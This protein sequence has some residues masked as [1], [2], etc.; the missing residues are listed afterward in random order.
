M[1]HFSPARKHS[2]EFSIFSHPFSETFFM[3]ALLPH[4]TLLPYAFPTHGVK[5]FST[6]RHAPWETEAEKDAEPDAYTSFN[7]THYCGDTPAHISRCRDWLCNKLDITQEQLW[8]PRQT[9][10]TRVLCIDANFIRSTPNKQNNLLDSVDA[11][12]TDIPRQCIGVSTA[13]CVPILLYDKKHR[14]VAA[15]HSGWR[16]TVGDIPGN[17]LRV[18]SQIYGTQACEV[19]AI[20]GPSISPQAFEVGTEVVNTFMQAGFPSSIVMDIYPNKHTA[21]SMKPHIDL[22]A[23]NSWLLEKCGIPLQ[24]IQI[25]GICS[26]QN[27]TDFFSARRLGIL[28]GRTFTGIMLE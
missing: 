13:D 14:V 23:A 26:Y 19:F 9:H 25:T 4:H 28:S 8:I 3:A 7:I 17:T 21:A 15:V 24:Q 16:G 27:H 22:W 6:S 1:S 11:L 18:M 2:C 12:I 5:A 20:L 10:S